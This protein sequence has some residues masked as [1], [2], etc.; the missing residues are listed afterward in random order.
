M[1]NLFKSLQPPKKETPSEFVRNNRYLSS[2]ISA[3]PGR[4]KD[5]P[6]QTEMMDCTEGSNFVVFQTGS[7]VGKTEILKNI[8]LYRIILT[9]TKK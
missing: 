6:Y 3:T 8:L 2:E 1:H 9:L 4:W 7:Q 5:I